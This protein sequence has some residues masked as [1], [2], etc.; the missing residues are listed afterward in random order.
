M[1]F[2]IYR[3]KI[4][5][6]VAIFIACLFLLNDIAYSLSPRVGNPET[7][8]EMCATGEK[9]FG[10]GR[11]TPDID[12]DL[13]RRP[14]VF[15]GK[16]PNVQGISF[17]VQSFRS[18]HIEKATLKNPILKETSLIKA[19]EVF[20]DTETNIPSSKLE[21]RAGYY[22]PKKA[23]SLT[24]ARIEKHGDKYI[25]IVHP[26]FI[27]MWEHI[28]QNDIWFYANIGN[29][30]RLTSVAWGLFYRLAKHEMADIERAGVEGKG[31]TT[32]LPL[33]NL[34]DVRE[35]EFLAN[36]T[37][38]NYSLV[39]D[40]IWLWF[41]GSFAFDDTT[42]Y[43]NNRL[44]N[45]LNWFFTGEEAIKLKLNE[46]FPN[47]LT[48]DLTRKHA[49]K[50]AC[51]INYNFFRDTSKHVIDLEVEQDLIDEWHERERL[52]TE[53]P[54]SAGGLD[55]EPADTPKV[56]HS[57]PDA[58]IQKIAKSIA[59][60][61][62]KV[63]DWVEFET[64]EF[65]AFSAIATALLSFDPT[66][67]ASLESW[68]RLKGKY[69][70]IGEMRQDGLLRR[71]SQKKIPKTRRFGTR[72][73]DRGK[74]TS[75]Q[76]TITDDH[77]NDAEQRLEILSQIEEVFDLLSPDAR[78]IIEL[79]YI[80]EKTMKQV[81]EALNLSESR[82]SQLH[83]R[84]MAGIKAGEK[85]SVYLR[86]KEIMAG[87]G[88]RI[89][90]ARVGKE[91]SQKELGERLQKK[92]GLINKWENEKSTPTYQEACE[93]A[94][95]LKV[96][97]SYILKGD[98]VPSW[99]LDKEELYRL[100][101]DWGARLR[102][103]RRAHYFSLRTIE[104]NS[105]IGR[106]SV[107]LWEREEYEPTHSELR[108]LRKIYK[109]RLE[110]ITK[111]T[112][113]PDWGKFENMEF[114]LGK[115][116]GNRI[117]R[118]MDAKEKSIQGLA[119][120]LKI[121]IGTLSDWLSEVQFPS[122]TKLRELT[123]ILYTSMSFIIDGTNEP[124]WVKA[125]ED[126]YR[127][128]PGFS[129]RLRRVREATGLTTVALAAKI[130]VDKSVIRSWEHVRYKPAPEN[131][132]KLAKILRV[133][134]IYFT[135]GKEKPNWQAIEERRT[136]LKA[137]WGTRIKKAREFWKLSWTALSIKVDRI[138]KIVQK[139]EAEKSVPDKEDIRKLAKI[140][141]IPVSYIAKGV[142]EPDW[143]V[144]AEKRDF[145]KP[146]WGER[147]KR[148][149]QAKELSQEALHEKMGKGTHLIYD[150]EHEEAHPSMEYLRKLAKVLRISMGFLIADT[151]EPAWLRTKEDLYKLEPGW[152][153]RL[154]RVREAKDWSCS[155]MQGLLKGGSMFGSWEREKRIPSMHQLEK[156]VSILSVPLQ[157]ITK[158]IDEPEWVKA[159]LSLYTFKPGW[160]KRIQKAREMCNMSKKNLSKLVGVWNVT[161]THWEN[162]DSRPPHKKLKKM[163][164]HMKINLVYI[165]RGENEPDWNTFAKAMWAFKPGWGKRLKKARKAM[166]LTL[167]D[168]GNKLGR[169]GTCIDYWEKEK[170]HPSKKYLQKL[171]EAL[172][173]SI[174]YILK[175]GDE[176]KWFAERKEASRVKRGWGKRIRKARNEMD[177]SAK[178]LGII[179]G[180]CDTT[181][182]AWELKNNK[183]SNQMFEKLAKALGVD[184]VYLVK[185][186]NEPDWKALKEERALLKSGWTKRI[187]KVR[188][189]L[190][191]KIGEFCQRAGITTNTW[192][193]WKSGETKNISKE[194]VQEVAK[195]LGI[196]FDYVANGIDEPNW[197]TFKKE[198]PFKPGWGARIQKA[199]EGKTLS[200]KELATLLKVRTQVISSWL[201]ETK[202]PTEKELDELSNALGVHIYYI[203]KGIYVP[204]KIKALVWRSPGWGERISKARTARSM[205]QPE[206][207][208]E[209]KKYFP[210]VKF[211][212]VSLWE[213]EDRGIAQ[214][215]MKKL[216]RIMKISFKYLAL[217]V[218]EPNWKI[219]EE[220]SA[221][222]KT[223]WGKRLRKARLSRGLSQEGLAGMLG[224]NHNRI[225]LY[226][227][228][229]KPQ[230]MEVLRKLAVALKV[231]FSY[232]ATGKNEPNWVKIEKES[233]K[234]Q[235]GWGKRIK[236][237]REALRLTQ[238]YVTE[239]LHLWRVTVS[240][241]EN[242]K[243]F[244]TKKNLDKLAKILNVSAKYIKTGENKP[245]WISKLKKKHAFKKGWG[246][247]IRKL[248][249]ALG[250]AR[251]ETG[252]RVGFHGSNAGKHIKAWE[253][254]KS[255]PSLEQV[256]EIAKIFGCHPDYIIKELK[257]PD[258]KKL[259]AKA[260]VLAPGW[261]NRIARARNA[262]G[263]TQR[264]LAK[265]IGHHHRLLIKWESEKSGTD[266]ETIKKLAKVLSVGIGF[267][268]RGGDT[269]A[270]LKAKEDLPAFKKGW[271]KRL[272]RLRVALDI[273]MNDLGRQLG[274]A[275]T[276]PGY[277][278]KKWEKGESRPTPR[279][280]QQLVEVFECSIEYMTEGT[281]EP[282]WE[283]LEQ[284][285]QKS[286]LESGWG[287]RIRLARK[288]KGLSQVELAKEV[289]V[290]PKTIGDWE[291]ERAE[292]S[293][294]EYIKKLAKALDVSAKYILKD[295]QEEHPLITIISEYIVDLGR[296][297]G[298]GYIT[299]ITDE[300]RTKAWK[301]ATILHN[302]KT[303]IILPTQF[304]FTDKI[305]KAMRDV[306]ERGKVRNVEYSTYSTADDLERIIKQK[307]PDGVKRIIL[308]GKHV[309]ASVSSLA[310][311]KPGLFKDIRVLHMEL[312]DEYYNMKGKE[313][314]VHQ[315]RIIMI[316]ILARLLEK[317]NSPIEKTLLAEML[318]EHLD[319]SVG[320]G[321]FISK[322]IESEDDKTETQ[323]K[324]R[325]EYFLSL[326]NAVRFTEKLEKEIELMKTFWKYA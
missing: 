242:E 173:I 68:V 122:K 293:S 118:L 295:T 211:T 202:H 14:N 75:E 265:K 69:I 235:P 256:K 148:A 190:G 54:I 129:K 204:L 62:K 214:N 258:W 163:A 280:L 144:L 277:M 244:P 161:L 218:N 316:A 187:E 84:I 269:P 97:R 220:E 103:A 290:H 128:T 110:Y 42:R 27:K 149:R 192:A 31:H 72:T 296:E 48:D 203:L 233:G 107:R 239:K 288:A 49:I 140:F 6:V 19:L 284:K 257:E 147:I 111:G 273:T 172:N 249:D 169:S 216:A 28:R 15:L 12:F 157:Y 286:A 300:Q 207:A 292:I 132:R 135:Q 287:G 67:K 199:M 176:P 127:M 123:R 90:R 302:S 322:L 3:H 229:S 281:N 134:I 301:A 94:K 241:W 262:K 247:R 326:E 210:S 245:Q 93:L 168:V 57:L 29:Q 32:Y 297:H 5:K 79:Y 92:Q 78:R 18:T 243:G 162:E 185:G 101:P 318:K 321:A 130:G 70:A 298:P 232:L 260:F 99:I 320:L 80:E 138:A 283:A 234:T 47:L 63:Y 74:E 289:N 22:K 307:K 113:E 86:P 312:P 228:G 264:Q 114:A 177:L 325:L 246:E 56:T 16:A 238:D 178:A 282:N 230:T 106:E 66:K 153:G 164:K 184:L 266:L 219:I 33:F 131:L 186:K 191:L 77:G 314:T 76:E 223:G 251:V 294:L 8:E 225:Y 274:Y 39:N 139:W 109:V 270:W 252:R 317:Q 104:E 112:N 311:S 261:G 41:L 46:E 50:L 206:V 108:T 175:D 13:F 143:Q 195:A 212:T 158:G 2:D 198:L 237:A 180:S 215:E 254:E 156:L 200:N 179:I 71:K 154:Q 17:P 23:G 171:S 306:G 60:R 25:L 26:Q 37:I 81:A 208:K 271:G 36:E 240:H 136:G 217:G 91:L 115:G 167:L 105:G 165:T 100:A 278:I 4:T 124:A 255:V 38:G 151:N 196:S 205:T 299:Q 182:S 116:W 51:A 159:R 58:R 236:E 291:N 319:S 150:L 267:I 313:K 248:R 43:R 55:E 193:N 9:L 268:M 224:I 10:V 61:L 96:S 145:L 305:Q 275:G 1:L 250:L 137:G 174:N 21:I 73:D 304:G 188:I 52:I 119:N 34:L 117:K 89:T 315:A 276:I 146:G 88:E 121:G 279:R 152:G 209:M 120:T 221:E 259:R 35:N 102:K 7:Y 53:K 141:K 226:E 285:G 133:P 30:P 189:A 85:V 142:N 201:N 183:P 83:K 222:I 181:I 170:T 98:I 263:L 20:R 82:I 45:R 59:K 213:H 155:H 197:D 194:R 24:I 303:E 87:F 95:T 126:L 231:K 11:E 310:I 166:D 40:A 308:T 65:Y 309:W 323:I 160:G 272:R 253:R 64:L 125:T 324:T 227:R 44:K